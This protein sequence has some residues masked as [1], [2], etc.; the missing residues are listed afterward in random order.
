MAPTSLRWRLTAWVAAVMIVSAVIVFVC[1][2]RAAPATSCER[3]ST[4]TCTGDTTQLS[5]RS[6]AFAGQAPARDRRRRAS[7]TSRTSPTARR[8]RCCS[9]LIP[10]ASTASNHP[11]LFGPA[12]PTTARLWPSRRRRTCCGARSDGAALG[13]RDQTVPDVGR[14]AD[15]S[16]DVLTIGGHSTSIAAPASRSLTVAARPA[17]HR[18]AFLLAGRADARAGA[19]SPPTSP[20]RG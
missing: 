3:R 2:L 6:A 9:S 7:D 10:G 17:R 20:A 15:R 14:V 12:D 4:A 8:R 16:N 19:A 1:R 13:L 18:R 5:R 11:E